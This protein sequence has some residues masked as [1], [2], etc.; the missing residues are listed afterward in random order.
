MS[1]FVEHPLIE[2]KDVP[3]EDLAKSLFFA[4]FICVS[5]TN[6]RDPILCYGNE[7]AL[8]LWGLDWETFTKTPSRKTVSEAER[9]DR[10]VLLSNAHKEGYIDN[11]HG[12]RINAKGKKFQISNVILWNVLDEHSNIIGQAAMFK[13]YC[14]L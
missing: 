4:P 9:A 7:K 6:A 3:P 5:H 12:I 1:I 13:D 10:E 14:F 8:E 11:Y 2:T